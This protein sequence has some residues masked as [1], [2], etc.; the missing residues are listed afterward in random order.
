VLRRLF[1]PKKDEMME[2]WTKLHNEELRNLHSSPNI[3][4]MKSRRMRRAKHVARLGKK[5]NTYRILVGK[6]KGKIP[7]GRPRRKWEDNIKMDHR[8][9]GWSGADWIN[10]AQ[11]RGQWRTSENT[12]MNLRV[13]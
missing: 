8:K 11:D 5:R 3:I 4:K 10:L 12:A 9:M 7:I 1:A 2:G 6:S 13:P